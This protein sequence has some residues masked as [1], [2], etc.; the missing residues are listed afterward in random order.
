MTFELSSGATLQ[1]SATTGD[2]QVVSVTG[3]VASAAER[4][5]AAL[6]LLEE[7]PS[8]SLL[9]QLQGFPFDRLV[10]AGRASQSPRYMW[11][12]D[13]WDAALHPEKAKRKRSR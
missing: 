10:D 13:Q 7:K 2:W 12:A 3:D 6:L 11:H 5:L 1:F 4:P 8:P 9:K